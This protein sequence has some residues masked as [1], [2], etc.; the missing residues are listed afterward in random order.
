MLEL[1]AD[2]PPGH[3]FFEQFSFIES[4]DLPE[5]QTILGRAA[6]GPEGMTD[7]DRLQLI[8]LPFK[9]IS[10]RHRLDLID[11]Q[12]M[13]RILE[14]RRAFA[15]NL[16]DT[17]A[18]NIA[19]FDAERYNS[20]ASLQDNILFGKLSYGQAQ[21]ENKVGALI[22]E[23]VDDLDLRETV[24]LAGLDFQAGIGGARLSQGQRQKIAIARGLLRQPDLLILNE[25]TASLDAASQNWI[26]GYVLKSSQGRGVVWVLNRVSDAQL[27]S[28]I[29]VLKSGRIVETGTYE[30]L[31]EAGGEFQNLLEAG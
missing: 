19:F 2:L 14:A 21:A 9:L 24:I 15:E 3:E 20:A 16:P 30:E 17:L 12:M 4:D 27:F 31:S 29:V 5:F 26:M 22:G 8:S 18:E 7:E 28:K 23:V 25:A 13:Q 6:R 10:A 1:F 11:E